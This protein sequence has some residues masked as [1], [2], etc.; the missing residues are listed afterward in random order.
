MTIT[1]EQLLSFPNMTEEDANKMMR[2]LTWITSGDRK[3]YNQRLQM[4]ADF[5]QWGKNFA[6]EA[7]ELGFQHCNTNY[8]S[9][10][11]SLFNKDGHKTI[12]KLDVYY[13]GCPSHGN[14]NNSRVSEGNFYA[15]VH[16]GDSWTKNRESQEVR[17]IEE[18]KSFLANI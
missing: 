12:A 8:S 3:K 13:A 11:Y 10:E 18:L 14:E 16:K 9:W 17:S 7:K 5:K 6:K 1:K 15:I 2:E 4:L